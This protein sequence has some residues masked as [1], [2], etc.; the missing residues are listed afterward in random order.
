MTLL[1]TLISSLTGP[2]LE[3]GQQ[4]PPFTAADCDGKIF[5]LQQALTHGPVVLAFYPKA[6]TQGCTQQMRAFVDQGSMMQKYRAQIVAVS[7]DNPKTLQ[8]F[9]EQLHAPFLFIPDEDGTLMRLYQ[10]KM[11]VVTVAK[12]KTFVIDGSGKIVLIIE[13]KDAIAQKGIEQALSA[14]APTQ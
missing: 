8:T 1:V 9:R 6:Q 10:S 14:L 13:G 11:P 2:D 3:V 4:A 12:R 7:R 5:D